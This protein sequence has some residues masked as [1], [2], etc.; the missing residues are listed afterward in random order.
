MGFP[1]AR[2]LKSWVLL[3]FVVNRPRQTL[4][5][6]PSV[7]SYSLAPTEKQ[8]RR[9]PLGAPLRNGPLIDCVLTSTSALL[10]L[11]CRLRI[12]SLFL[13]SFQLYVALMW[14][15]SCGELQRWS[16]DQ[17]GCL[18]C[19]FVFLFVFVFQ[20][21]VVILFSA[22]WLRI[23]WSIK[24]LY[25]FMLLYLHELFSIFSVYT[26]ENFFCFFF[27]FILFH[28]LLQF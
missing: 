24:L 27:I 21:S 28:H 8:G 19:A 26:N 11:P 23:R 17:T 12:H 10:H 7:C 16:P 6:M 2:L 13:I 18:L 15:L 5:N 25:F 3:V 4:G 1:W 20:F 9:V 22:L 14:L